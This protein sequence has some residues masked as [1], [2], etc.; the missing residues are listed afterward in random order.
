M[1]YNTIFSLIKAGVKTDDWD[2]Q[3]DK[4]LEE[5]IFAYGF[6]DLVEPCTE[7]LTLLINGGREPKPEADEVPDGEKL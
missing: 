4:G 2:K 6:S 7:Y 3:D 1:D 5:K